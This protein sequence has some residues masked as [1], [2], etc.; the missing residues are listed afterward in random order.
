MLEHHSDAET[1][2][3]TRASNLNRVAL[4][5]DVACGRLQGTKEHLYERRLAGTVLAQQGMDLTRSN[6]QVDI[7]VGAQLAKLL[8]E[9]AHLEQAVVL[10]WFVGQHNFLPRM[11]R[12]IATD[13]RRSG[14]ISETTN[15][16]KELQRIEA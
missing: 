7:V 9:A 5:D 6:F 1:A 4:P 3:L 14:R 12:I 11:M 15:A 2:R 13:P 8:G 16:A 10:R